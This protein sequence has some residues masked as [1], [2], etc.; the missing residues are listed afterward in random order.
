VDLKE[1]MSGQLFSQEDEQAYAVL[2]GASIPDLLDRLYDADRPEFE[3]LYRGDLKPD[4]AEVAPYLVR[5]EPES[6]FTEWVV[7]EGWGQ[8]WG[9]F[10][11]TPA[12]LRSLRQH[13]RRLNL[14]YGPEHKPLLF[15]YYDPRVLRV[16]VPTCDGPQLA[17]LFGPVRCFILED[18]D[19]GKALRLTLAE[20]ILRQ[21]ASA[22]DLGVRS[23]QGV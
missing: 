7:E 3:C 10:A 23:G 14:V 11:V 1:W 16:F 6:G 20:G 9:I 13:F 18:A 21:E 15:R 12:D 17:E 19:P 22:I 8:H 5:L 2:D 4:L